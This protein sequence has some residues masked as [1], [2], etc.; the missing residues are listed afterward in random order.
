MSAA[1]RSRHAALWSALLPCLML[2]SLAW[3]ADALLALRQFTQEVRSGRANF[4][5][6]VTSVDGVR[7]RVSSGSFEFT[8][9]DR[10]RFAYA[11]PHEQLIVADGQRVWLYDVELNQVT[12]RA[13]SQAL[14]ATPTAL[15][16]GAAL[17]RDFELSA[18][19]ASDGVDW[20]LALPR[21]KEGATVESI[22]VGFRGGTLAALEMRDVFGQRSMLQFS[23][24][25]ANAKL[26]DE[27]F[28]F[29]P[30]AGADVIGP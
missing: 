15:L 19:P 20:V 21:Q 8:R 4:V 30:P 6:T 24:V 28:R 9:P 17:E 10:F 14:G 18:Q 1:A 26:G 25:V 27:R 2:P 23:D 7:K 22:R 29:T 16:A 5:Q 11:K 3:S 13:M 12:V